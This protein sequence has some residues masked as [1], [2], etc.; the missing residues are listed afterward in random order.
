ME[1]FDRVGVV[2]DE[3]FND[4]QVVLVDR[5]VHESNSLDVSQ[6]LGAVEDLLLVLLLVLKF[7]NHV[8]ES[9]GNFVAQ[10]L[11]N[12]SQEQFVFK[13]K[14]VENVLHGGRSEK[15]GKRF[16]SVHVVVYYFNHFVRLWLE[17]KL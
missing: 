2:V 10:L 4:L 8:V 17:N 5:E 16:R 11:G 12:S 15:G 3:V 7:Y 14:H 9:L 6:L 1:V 13:V